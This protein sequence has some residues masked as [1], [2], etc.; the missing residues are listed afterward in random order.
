V[1]KKPVKLRKIWRINP[2]T[3]VKKNKK[4][5][6]RTRLKEEIRKAMKNEK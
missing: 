3:Q 4:I 1:L 6:L 2:A 5:Y